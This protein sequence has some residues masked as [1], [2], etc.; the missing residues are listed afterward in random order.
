MRCKCGFNSFDHNLACPKCHKDLTATRRLLNLEIPAPGGVNFFQI[1]GQRMATPQ[2]FLGAAVGGED[3][4][5]DLQPEDIQPVAYSASQPPPPQAPPYAAPP[6][7]QAP[8]YAA[9]PPPPQVFAAPAR[10]AAAPVD[11]PM[12]EI[13]VTDDFE[14]DQPGN[15]AQAEETFTPVN[16]LPIHQAAMNQIKSTLT[17]TGDLAPEAEGNAYVLGAQ[18]LTPAAPAPNRAAEGGGGDDF[19]SLVGDVNLDDLEGDL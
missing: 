13:E 14:A 4:P 2:P 19:S 18:D 11:E 3:F 9:P 1:A 10:P 17:E 16:P 7:P 5:G 8:P 6:P 12:I 15:R